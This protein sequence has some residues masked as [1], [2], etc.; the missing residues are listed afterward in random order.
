MKY[1][2]I[3]LLGLVLVSNG[4]VEPK[5]E[6]PI[7]VECENGLLPCSEDSTECCEVICPPGYYLGGEDST[8][9]LEITCPPGYYLSGE[10]SIECLEIICPPGYHLASPDSIECLEI[11]CPTG[12]TLGGPDSSDCVEVICEDHFHNCGPNLAVCCEDSVLYGQFEPGD[13]LE[14]M[15]TYWSSANSFWEN[16]SGIEIWT[17]ANDPDEENILIIAAHVE[18]TYSWGEDDP[19]DPTEALSGDVEGALNKS[20]G[21]IG[22]PIGDPGFS[23][24]GN[25]LSRLCY[26]LKQYEH[27]GVMQDFP[28]LFGPYGMDSTHVEFIG[29][30][31]SGIWNE[32]FYSYKYDLNMSSGIQHLQFDYSN[33]AYG[34]IF[35]WTMDLIE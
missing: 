31:W 7:F 22:S 23:I 14:Y 3:I 10:D 32:G 24:L 20:T 29:D 27:H 28:G 1:L 15:V 6:L 9:C 30:L 13:T 19:D 5:N 21:K 18:G 34:H 4:C 33:I 12:F 26:D 16:Y 2:K 8:D 17:F 25:I 35:K 11:E